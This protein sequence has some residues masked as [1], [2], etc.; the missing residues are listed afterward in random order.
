METDQV[1]V[2]LWG[3]PY[4]A[5]FLHQNGWMSDDG[6]VHGNALPTNSRPW[7]SKRIG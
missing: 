1:F 2:L 6:H 4:V 7:P 5:D 3:M